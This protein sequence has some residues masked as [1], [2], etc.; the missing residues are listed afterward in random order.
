MVTLWLRNKD[1]NTSL[2]SLIKKQNQLEHVSTEADIIHDRTRFRG[3]EYLVWLVITQWIGSPSVDN[4][5]FFYHIFLMI[6]GE[7]WWCPWIAVFSSGCIAHY[8]E[9]RSRLLTLHSPELWT[10]IT[11]VSFINQIATIA[12]SPFRLVPF[13]P[14]LPSLL[15]DTWQLYTPSLFTGAP[16]ISLKTKDKQTKLDFNL[17]N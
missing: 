1:T 9:S 3:S 6:F 16:N 8:F 10:Y 15:R 17:L 4:L 13:F 7:K 2:Q 12:N 11:L 5:F 14:R